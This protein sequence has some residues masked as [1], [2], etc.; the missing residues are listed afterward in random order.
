M[1]ELRRLLH[2][3][4]EPGYRGGQRQV[5]ILL[6]EQRRDPTLSVSALVRS[7]QLRDELRSAGVDVRRWPGAVAGASRLVLAGRTHD[8]LHVHDARAH[9]LARLAGWPRPGRA[10]IVHRRVDDPPHDRASTRWKYAGGVF[11]CVS[12]AVAAVLR[13]RGVPAA[14]LRV[15][16]SAVELGT[17]PPPP[18][19]VGPAL[20]FAA[21][22]ALVGHKGHA[23]L[24]EALA[25]CVHAHRLRLVGDGPLRG[26][27]L[28]QRERLG[29]VGRVELVGDVGEGRLEIATA[30]AFVHPSRTEGLGTAVLDAM[31][32]GRPVVA[33]RA[34][35]LPEICDETTG[36]TAPPGDPAALAACLD[37]LGELAATAPSA[38]AALGLRGRDR[39]AER[40]TPE[41]LSAA[42]RAVYD[43]F[44]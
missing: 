18:G 13:A 28:A 29:L 2:V 36:R 40:H 25:R 14:R 35:G 38:F 9:G 20:R 39:V 5:R 21:L 1:P 43:E 16:L 15:A 32:A 41:R 33:T 42:V 12:E 34:G 37:S 31:A 8:L 44:E 26:A 6:V 3:D 11:V 10:L 4:A 17:L 24:L 19:P 30:H 23:D 7:P 27:L 22:G